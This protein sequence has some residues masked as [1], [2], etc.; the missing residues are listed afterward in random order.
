MTTTIRKPLQPTRDIDLL[1]ID[2]R[3]IFVNR[4][5]GLLETIATLKKQMA[6]AKQQL[7]NLEEQS[8]E[9]EKFATSFVLSNVM[10]DKPKGRK[11]TLDAGKYDLV[12]SLPP[13]QKV[14]VTDE[15]L[16][17]KEYSREK[18]TVTLNK[19]A[20]KADLKRN[21]EVPGAELVD[22]DPTLT[23]VLKEN[24]VKEDEDCL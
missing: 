5:L 7:S 10:P 18:I 4:Q 15:A 22:S 19:E 13:T 16:I 20:I 2:E 21:R 12:V 14:V 3:E 1:N 24:N 17:P 11:Y 8:S 9:M 23:L 6:I